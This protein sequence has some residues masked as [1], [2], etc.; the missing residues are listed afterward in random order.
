V[1]PVSYPNT[2]WF[3]EGPQDPIG[4]P[5]H[6]YR[7]LPSEVLFLVI[8]RLQGIVSTW[9]FDTIEAHR[10]LYVVCLADSPLRKGRFESYMKLTAHSV[11]LRKGCALFANS[12]TCSLPS[13]P[14][15]GETA[16]YWIRYVSPCHASAI[17]LL[18]STVFLGVA[19]FYR[20]MWFYWRD[21]D[22]YSEGTR[23]VAEHALG[24]RGTRSEIQSHRASYGGC[25]SCHLRK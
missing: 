4:Q 2:P 7:L 6:R 25:S 19:D 8:F 22:V 5:R 12:T 18:H 24:R 14:R 21:F 3:D 16:Y 1:E 17:R 13:E 10:Q 9:C 15:R 20:L 23:S 11:S